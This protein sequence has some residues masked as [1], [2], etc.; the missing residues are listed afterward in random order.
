MYSIILLSMFFLHIVDDFYLQGIFKDLKQKRWWEEHAPQKIYEND[1][2]VALLEHSFSW[3]FV[4]HIP[5]ILFMVSKGSIL[6]SWIPL[7]IFGNMTIHAIIDDLKANKLKINLI[8]DQL[9][10]LIQ[11]ILIFILYIIIL[12]I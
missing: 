5:I 3:S 12:G 10:H 6:D 1:Y 8:T 2:L 7:T 9:L 4:I 11:I